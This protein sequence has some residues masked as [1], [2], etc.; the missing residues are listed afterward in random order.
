MRYFDRPVLMSEEIHRQLS[1]IKIGLIYWHVSRAWA[2]ALKILSCATNRKSWV[3]TSSTNYYV[4]IKSN[5]FTLG[6]PRNVLQPY[7][8][9]LQMMLAVLFYTTF[10]DR[11]ISPLQHRQ[12]QLAL[13]Y[14]SA[15]LYTSY[16]CKVWVCFGTSGFY[17]SYISLQCSSPKQT[18][19]FVFMIPPEH[20]AKSSSSY[21]TPFT[22]SR[23][24]FLQISALSVCWLSPFFVCFRSLALLVF[25]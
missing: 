2:A 23:T 17:F 9:I 12:L 21:L 16:Q 4:G 13:V 18:Q 19:N 3:K 22:V 8:Q 25:K 1:W 7:V 24:L 20:R 5:L 11:P 6:L 10:G 14:Q 15:H